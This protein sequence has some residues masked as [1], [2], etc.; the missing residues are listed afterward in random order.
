MEKTFALFL[1]L[2]SCVNVYTQSTATEHKLTSRIY[3][4]ITEARIETIDTIDLFVQDKGHTSARNIDIVRHPQFLQI[5][6]V[7]LSQL[8]KVTDKVFQINIPF[9]DQKLHLKLVRATPTT[10]EFRIST[11]S[12]IHNLQGKG[13]H[14]RGIVSDD[15]GSLVAI[16]VFEDEVMAMISRPQES[17]IVLAKMPGDSSH[18]IYQ[19]D[20]IQG[21]IP[22]SCEAL[23]TPGYTLPEVRKST[24]RSTVGCVKVFFEASYSL[25]QNFEESEDK[26][27]N[28]VAGIF[29]QVSTLYANEGVNLLLSD[30]YIWTTPDPYNHENS[31]TALESFMKA[32]LKGSGHL[33]QL[34]D[35]IDNTSGGRAYVDVLCDKL[36]NVGY[37]NISPFYLTV[38]TYSWTVNVIAHELG[39][40]LGSFHTQDCVWGPE[41]CTAID[42]CAEPS[43]NVGCG[44]CPEAP[45]PDKGTLMSYCH[46]KNGIDFSLGLGDEPGDL[47]RSRVSQAEC[48]SSCE[49][50][51]EDVCQL[52]IERVDVRSTTC[53]N[54]NGI[55]TVELSGA[56]G[57]ETYDIG[58]GPQASNRFAGLSAGKYQVIVRDGIGCSRAVDINIDS[59]SNAPTL[60][61]IVTN[62]TCLGND[63]EVEFIASGGTAPYSFLF[64]NDTV[65][66]SIFNHLSPG[67]YEIELID[68]AGCH[69]RKPFSIY[70][71][72]AP[73]V[74]AEIYA[75]RCGLKNGEISLKATGGISPYS[76][77]ITAS[78]ADHH[79]DTTIEVGRT[80]LLSMLSAGV[81]DIYLEDQQGCIDSQSVQLDSSLPLAVSLS[82]H[83]ASCEKSNGSISIE[84]RG[85]D[86]PFHFFIGDQVLT[87]PVADQLQSGSYTV[88]VIDSNQCEA[89]ASIEVGYDTTFVAPDLPKETIL[90]AGE[91]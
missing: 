20:Q 79:I 36:L 62:A 44:S 26:V 53:G 55:M 24:K 14:F 15:P 43:P 75:T 85:G 30:L 71:D 18:I 91:R 49:D 61:A 3:R 58:N 81:Y 7:A 89:M 90:C 86:G 29:N 70:M 51:A 13:Q 32:P 27:A 87:G 83:P 56:S 74:E 48:I 68:S 54:E 52:A 23:M 2:Y 11:S 72:P 17:V 33:R 4:A 50:S 77:S 82:S 66:A 21:S 37:S 60:E 1:L 64:E 76:I 6:S 69:F 63:G 47:I 57:T 45:I 10:P 35:I 38:P 19:E 31:T 46:T 73:R 28:Y 9:H 84:L 25:Y 65:S 34:L 67:D 39:H 78:D 80:S 22:F 16:S 5:N 12:G 88:S 8:Q 42:G 41:H 40:G 59:A